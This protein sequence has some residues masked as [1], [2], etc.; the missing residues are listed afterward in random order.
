MPRESIPF[1]VSK[2]GNAQSEDQR[3]DDKEYLTF[4]WRNLLNVCEFRFNISK[5]I[6]TRSNN[7]I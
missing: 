3:K 6:F 7:F 4:V 1:V 2:S 5:L